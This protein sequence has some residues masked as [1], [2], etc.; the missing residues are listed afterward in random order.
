MKQPATMRRRPFL[1]VLAAAPLAMAGGLRAAP[2]AAKVLRYAFPTAETGFD[3]AQV[4]DLY[5]RTITAHIFE[6]PYD[7]DHL[8]RPYK[9]RPVTA[10][11]L[12]EVSDDY[13]AFIVR[14]APGIFFS[15]DAAFGGKP[16]ELVAADYVYSWKRV[17]NPLTKS[18]SQSVLEEQGIVGLRE[19]RDEALR[20]KRFDYDRPVEGLRA[21]D[22]YTLR[23]TLRESR[24]RFVFTLASPDIYGAVAR[25]V[26]EK[27]G[28]AIM[29]HPVGTGPFAL[30]EWRRSSKIVLERNPRYRERVYD[31]EPNHDDTEGQR[32]AQRFK[33]QR[34]PMLDRV[35]VS[36]IEEAQ[37]RWLA[38]LNGEH[39]LLERLPGEFVG[40]AVPGGQLAP[41]L[42]KRGIRHYRVPASDIR[43]TVYNMEHP[44]LGGYAPERIALRRAINLSL[45]V[46]REIA[47]VWRGEAIPAQSIVPPMTFGYDPE[48]RTEMGEHSLAR[49]K[50]LLDL[51]GYIDR[52]GDGWREQPDGSALLLE[53]STQSDQQTRQWDE[54]WKKNV[55][56]L[57]VR[58][59]LRPGQWA[60]NLKAV[61]NGKFMVWRVG[62]SASSPDG[63]G[64]LERC[65]GPSIGK[66]NLARFKLKA[67]DELYERMKRLP[68]GTE[69]AALFRDAAKLMVAYAPYRFHTHRIL[70]D[71]VH[72]QVVGFRRPSFWQGWWHYVDIARVPD[73]R[74]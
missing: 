53:L 34:L 45:D 40:Q 7:Y 31:A 60:E 15:D 46:Q 64:A 30:K 62:S 72:P 10:V 74:A 55:D 13:R 11:A 36:I 47:L 51:Y 29:A 18:P 54:V 56:A 37:P 44:V 69:R 35:E 6:A 57:G 24:P 50:A 68:D 33:G 4:S 17:Y 3:P 27:Y 1:G 23:I 70:T 42:A 32:H 66:G 19:L 9:L 14:L 73:A 67:F 2:G 26:I 16:R 20:T 63:Q 65:Y 22:R 39:D 49:A 71:L 21:I 43:L 48:L 28:D 38:F 59:E 25:E 61:R 5:S 12:P 58:V 52:N 41:H 8:A